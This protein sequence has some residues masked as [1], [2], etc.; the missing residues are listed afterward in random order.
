MTRRQWAR[1]AV[2]AMW[3]AAVAEFA[4]LAIWSSARL[5]SSIAAAIGAGLLAAGFGAGLPLLALHIRG[6]KPQ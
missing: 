3:A 5:T 4:L 1:R 6:A 2:I